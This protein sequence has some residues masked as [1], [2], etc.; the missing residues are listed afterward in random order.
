MKHSTSLSIIIVL[1][2][3]VLLS[4][5]HKKKDTTPASEPTPAVATCFN[6]L[7]AGTYVGSG[8]IMSTP[9]T[10]GTL[11]INKLTCQSINLDLVTNTG[12]G[13][14]TQASQLTLDNSGSYN[15]KLNNGNNVSLAPGSNLNVNA[16]GSF[17][18]NGVKK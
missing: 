12:N 6:S 13:I 5:C 2:S 1:F 16:V 4:N 17:T 8:I 11:T 3:I 7:I 14:T 15:G 9:F 18:F 10:S